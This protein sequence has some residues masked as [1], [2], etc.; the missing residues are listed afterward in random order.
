MDALLHSLP[1]MAKFVIA[2]VVVL[3]VIGAGFYLWKRFGSGRPA[4]AGPRGR[5]PRLSVTDFADVDGRRRLILIR[6][7]DVEHLVMIGGQ[8]DVVIESNIGRAAPAAIPTPREPRFGPEVALRPPAEIPGWQPPVE[9]PARALRPAEPP[10]PA[11]PLHAEP[12]APVRIE[13]TVPPV[14][15]LDPTMA[16]V[17]PSPPE[18][19]QYA[20]QTVLAPPLTAAMP[21]APPGF[22]GPENSLIQPIAPM[23][24]FRATQAAP[25]VSPPPPPPL[26]EPVFQADEPEP[27]W[28]A[29]PPPPPL[30]SPPA[31][32]PEP[33]YQPPYQPPPAEPQRMQQPPR[34]SQSDES[35]LAEMAQRLEAA[36]RRP[37]R[38]G[39]APSRTVAPSLRA[40]APEQRAPEPPAPSPVSLE[41]EMANLLGRPSG[42]T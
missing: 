15:R 9:P 37:T 25:P 36:L 5:Q 38:T 24:T 19:P 18:R 20:E 34:P 33:Q 3:G 29:A 32:P 10:E 13:P 7:D 23:P 31:P 26:L 12:A 27:L 14:Q 4:A 6:R 16:P 21:P 42:K 17:P 28:A 1:D 22:A 35:N 39:D 2:F 41:D 30:V 40:V 11:V 8:S